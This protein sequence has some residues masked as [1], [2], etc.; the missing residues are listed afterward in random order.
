MKT[1]N[2]IMAAAAV[3]FMVSCSSGEKSRYF[4]DIPSITEEYHE[5]MLALQ[6]KAPDATTEELKG[7]MAENKALKEEFGKRVEQVAPSVVG[8]ELEYAVPDGYEYEVVSAPTIRK[9]YMFS[10]TQARIYIAVKMRAVREVS[11]DGDLYKSVYLKFV[12]KEG[13]TVKKRFFS[14]TAFNERGL[15]PVGTEFGSEDIVISFN[16]DDDFDG[17]MGSIDRVVFISEEEYRA[18]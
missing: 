16:V 8:T 6:E 10:S 5:K 7:L 13:V 12:D 4:G 9:A 14:V 3:V 1:R 18:D 11:L 17:R 2:V 15:M